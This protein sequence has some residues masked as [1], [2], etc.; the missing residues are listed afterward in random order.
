MCITGT[1]LAFEK[2]L[3]AWSERDARRVEIPENSSG[4]LSLDEIQ[5]VVNDSRPS[6]P[7]ASLVLQNDPGA[8]IAVSGLGP[9]PAGTLYVNPYTGAL[10]QPKST[11]MAAFMRAATSWHRYLNLTG[12]VARPRGRLVNGVCNIAFSVLTV[13]GLYLW[14]PRS[15]SW[16]RV[17]GVAFIRASLRG[18]A[19]DFNWHNAIGFWTAPGLLVLTLT[20]MPISFRWAANSLYALT[21]TP[22]PQGGG[23]G[24]GG[25]PTAP[26]VPIPETARPLGAD[27]LVAV[28]QA[29]FPAWEQIT[30]RAGGWP[31]RPATLAVR[32]SVSWPRTATTTLSL[33]PY[34][35]A[36]LRREGYAKMN[37]AQ[38]LRSWTRFLHT[39]EALGIG[40]QLAAA[41]ACLGGCFLVYTG[42][43]LAWRRFVR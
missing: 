39:G 25:A 42:F 26:P 3:V 40:G 16:S 14:M 38:K 24:R 23:A 6:S 28:A 32:T 20:A 4:R 5:R 21:G 7:A 35:G 11:R 2:Q 27:A 30:Y 10:A 17:R 34:T 36:V 8:A 22:M 13:S 15:W 12:P 18:K 29:E 37:A 19:R 43:A 31:G 33:D 9:S 1:V 41:L